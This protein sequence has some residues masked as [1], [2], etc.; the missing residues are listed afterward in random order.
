MKSSLGGGGTAE[1][2]SGEVQQVEALRRGDEEAF[3]ALVEQYHSFL[4]RLAGL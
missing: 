3:L 4:I 1:T 2:A